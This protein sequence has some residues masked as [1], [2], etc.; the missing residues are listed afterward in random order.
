[1]STTHLPATSTLPSSNEIHPL[2]QAAP[3]AR[4]ETLK[5]IVSP[6]AWEG[7]Q[8]SE[9]GSF[10]VQ[11][12]PTDIAEVDAALA[13]FQATG[14]S[15]G[16]LS[17]LTF[18][19]PTLGPRLRRLSHRVHHE[20]GFFVLR[21]LEP[22][23]YKRLENTIVFTGIA[24][25][26]G[27]RRGMQ[28]ADGPVMTHIFD[29]STEVEEM[30][31]SND[32]YLGHANRTSALPFHT[33]DG[34][35]ISLY[36][37][38]TADIG[39][40][41]LLASSWAIYNRLLSTRP[42]VIQTLKEA[43]LWDSFIPENPSFERPLLLEEDG[44]LI[45]NY[46]IRP[47]LGTPGYPRNAAMGPLPKHQEEALSVVGQIAEEICLKFEFKKGDIQ[48]VNNL[49][50][51]HAREEF[52]RAVGENTRRH[53]LRLVQMDDELGW[54]LPAVMKNPMEK[55]FNHEPDEEKFIWSPEPL[56]YVIGQ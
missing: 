19:L 55:M 9:E 25:H 39:G 3:H 41:T 31:K 7:D 45:C 42:D 51:L 24:S 46:R 36:C 17:P 27:N 43:W 10:V 2:Y 16:H 20:E 40:R 1:M 15:A 13:S 6:M 47:F 53:L 11:L 18:V 34:H 32:G 48:F 35:I 12:S 26:I 37:L 44:K 54:K 30:E 23:R 22:W 21:G 49:S 5:P 4:Q 52:H 56:P 29:Y 38:Q 50:L 28:S 14:L 33:D 8:F